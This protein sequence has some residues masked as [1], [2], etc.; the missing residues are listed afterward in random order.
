MDFADKLK[1]FASRVKNLRSKIK[2]EEATKTSMVMPLFSLLGYDVFNPLEFIPEYTADVGI[3]KGEKVDY[4]IVD[5]K[6]NPVVLIEVKYCG[7][8]LDKHGSQLFRYFAA[9]SAKFGILTNGIIYQ[10]YTDLDEL[11]KMDKKPF[12][13]VDFAALKDSVIPYLQRF[14]KATF[15]V[16]A[17]TA[18]ANEL[19]YSDQIRFFLSKQISDP[20]DGF[21]TYVISDIHKGRKTQRVIEDFRPLVRRAFS[22]LINDKANERLQ[23]ALDSEMVSRDTIIRPTSIENVSI[24]TSVAI[25]AATSE[26]GK[27]SFEKPESFYIV[28]VLVHECL[29]THNLN[30]KGDDV[31]LEIF[32]DDTPDRWICRLDYEQ[33]YLYIN[34]PAADKEYLKRKIRSTDDVYFYKELL[35]QAVQRGIA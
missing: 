23:T 31:H 13:V 9:T 3:K 17:V 6:Q 1:E 25:V 34:L 12:L 5:K 21:V 16:S 30:C 22:Q 29:S 26:T 28:K 27:A 15:N 14:E 19:R 7:E 11:N 24:E 8:N 33:N 18:Q 10:F 20:D 2:T 4:A 35:C 32:L